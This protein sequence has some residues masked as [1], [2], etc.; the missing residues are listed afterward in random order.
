VRV[1]FVG[2]T[3]TSHGHGVLAH[4]LIQAT[5]NRV[6]WKMIGTSEK[7]PKSDF[8]L[9][10]VTSG[11]AMNF[12]DDPGLPIVLHLGGNRSLRSE[13]IPKITKVIAVAPNIAAI[14]SKLTSKVVLLE[15]AV[16]ESFMPGPPDPALQKRV[17][18]VLYVGRSY[19][20]KRTDL[21]IK[22]FQDLPYDL[23]MVGAQQS[24]P[25]VHLTPNVKLWGYQQDTLKFYRTAD[26]FILPSRSEG[27]CLA[28]LEAMACGMPCIVSDVPENR[29][30]I[31][32]GGVVCQLNVESIQET[33]RQ[34]LS[35]PVLQADLS[36]RALAVSQTRSYGEWV[37]RLLAIFEEACSSS[38]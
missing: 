11:A 7:I 32:D 20:I 18:T 8:D 29:E 15:N 22:S 28:L 21:L 9:V 3:S 23:W 6:T 24:F 5:Q 2:D 38:S 14:L 13:W 36:R 16:P 4:R 30:T 35:N 31:C 37:K 34:V 17:P 10:Y 12:M 27:M 25:P 33:V 1:A 19:P 26:A